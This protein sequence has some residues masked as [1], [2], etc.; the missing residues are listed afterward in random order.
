LSREKTIDFFASCAFNWNN[1]HEEN[2]IIFFALFF[3]SRSLAALLDKP[4]VTKGSVANALFM[5]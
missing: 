1:P 4:A 3:T 5:H 2:K